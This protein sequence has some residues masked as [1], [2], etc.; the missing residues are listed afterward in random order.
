MTP[1]IKKAEKHTDKKDNIFNNLCW[2][3]LMAACRSIQMVRTYHPEKKKKKTQLQLDQRSPH[4]TD[5]LN[6]RAEKMGE[7]P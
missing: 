7:Q 2:S 3:N 5:T 1:F 4:K 6:L